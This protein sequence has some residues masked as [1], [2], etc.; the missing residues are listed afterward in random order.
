M[1]PSVV[2]ETITSTQFSLKHLSLRS[3]LEHWARISDLRMD[4]VV[5]CKISAP[6]FRDI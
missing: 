1:R 2:F 3:S 6:C 5:S 4:G